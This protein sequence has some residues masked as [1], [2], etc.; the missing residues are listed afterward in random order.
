MKKCGLNV[1]FE[2]S[3]IYD[4]ISR[5]TPMGDAFDP[6][7]MGDDVATTSQKRLDLIVKDENLK[8]IDKNNDAEESNPFAIHDAS[9]NFDDDF[10]HTHNDVTTH[11]ENDLS[12]QTSTTSCWPLLFERAAPR[13]L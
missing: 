11:N 1:K 10:L 2:F 8:N 5:A 13:Y 7:G 3:F 9:P 4:F 12:S 6:G